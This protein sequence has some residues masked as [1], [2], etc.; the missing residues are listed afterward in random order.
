MRRILLSVVILIA[1]STAQRALAQR[2]ITSEIAPTGKLRVAVN[3]GTPVQLTRTPDGK[4]TG[5]VAFE[6]G[7][8]IADKLGVS[9]AMTPYQN[10][11]SFT[12]S[13]GNGEWDIAIGVKTPLV[14]DKADFVQDLLFSDFLFVAGQG[15]EFADAAEVDRPG[16]KIGVGKNS[17]SDQFLSKNLRSAELVHLP[18][19][20]KS[21][22]A[23]QSG[24]VDVLA[25]SAS[26]VEQVAQ[27]L[28]GT[29]I[30]RT[31]FT[32]EVSMLILPKGRSSEARAK[33]TEIANDAKKAGVIKKAID[34]VGTTAVRPAP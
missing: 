25:A 10:A 22:E 14:A 33:I 24:Q 2:S 11:L 31:P 3:A 20:E 30:V 16:V 28:P 23:L 9:L 15:R 27:R 29:K 26:N 34:Q 7:K 32:S 18:G 6:L 5:G 1:T 13:F 12:Q 4:I 19:G 21:L 17:V 8:F